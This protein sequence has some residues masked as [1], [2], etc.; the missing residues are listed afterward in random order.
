M[1]RAL[2]WPGPML[3]SRA[4]SPMDHAQ[5]AELFSDHLEGTLAAPKKAELEQHLGVCIQ[6]RTDLEGLR[7]TMGGLGRLK[8]GAPPA[9]LE[10]IQ[11]QI[12][13][14]SRGRFYGKRALLFGRIPFEWLSL[15]TIIAMLVYYIVVMHG[16][17]TGVNPAP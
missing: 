2:P 4:V 10:N 12:N 1:T 6:C 3:R 13:R 16:S 15:A 11:A 5:A 8:A 9:F 7:R 17:P 14:R